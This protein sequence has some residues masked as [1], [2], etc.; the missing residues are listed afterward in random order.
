MKI[1]RIFDRYVLKEFIRVMTSSVLGFTAL[2][3]VVDVFEKISY[4][5]DRKVPTSIMGLYYLYKIPW[6]VDHILPVALLMTCLFTIGDMVK[7]NE[8]MIMQAS[9]ISI[10]RIFLPIFIFGFLMSVFSLGLGQSIVPA[11]DRARR[12]LDEYKIKKT[13]PINK[14]QRHN[15]FYKG[16]KGRIYSIKFLDVQRKRLAN[17]N[18]EEYDDKGHILRRIN[19]DSMFWMEKYWKLTR[20][21]IRYFKDDNVE[22]VEQKNEMILDNL[23]ETWEDFARE[24]RDPDEMTYFEL[25]DYIKRLKRGGENAT[26]YIVDLYLKVTSPFA[27]LII[28]ILG[29]PLATLGGAKGNKALSFGLGFIISFIYFLVNAAAQVLG[30]NGNLPP[31]LAANTANGLFLIIG[32]I[33]LFMARKMA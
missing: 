14:M 1:A 15:V 17:I 22:K 3:L 10:Y 27:N 24:E 23:E 33:I 29:A 6:I 11:S 32:F 25:K 19:A 4:F 21:Y 5:V 9:G 31:V 16:T 18:I 13:N 28:V 7:K 2:F 12:D 30:Q 26:R 8:V 20:V